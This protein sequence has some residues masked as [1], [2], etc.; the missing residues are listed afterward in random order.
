MNIKR[1]E[2]SDAKS[3]RDHAQFSRDH[4]GKIRGDQHGNCV[5]LDGFA[6]VSA[7]GRARCRECGDRIAKGDAAIPIYVSF[8]DGSYNPWTATAAYIHFADCGVKGE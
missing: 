1:I 5:T 7:S 3:I 6:T 2:R 8:S 4:E